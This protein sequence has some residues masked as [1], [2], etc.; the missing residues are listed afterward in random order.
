MRRVRR[1]W[2]F[3]V[4]VLGAALGCDRA[5]PPEPGTGAKEAARGF[6]EALVRQDWA[7]A[8]A[9][10]DAASRGRC[11]AGAFARLAEGYR[12]QLGFEP[13]AVQV[14]AC[15]ER[16][17]EAT[18]HVALTG[19]GAAR[20]RF[21]RDAVTLRREADGWRVVLPPQFGPAAGPR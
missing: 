7:G 4:V 9:A 17:A 16:G 5:A 6:F 11:G 15:E 20:H 13:T 14:R 3:G 1:T 19:R 18:A 10:L 2:A 21:Y 12:R 8:Y